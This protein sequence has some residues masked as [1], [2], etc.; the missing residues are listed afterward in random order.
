[1]DVDG[2]IPSLFCGAVWCWAPRRVDAE[3]ADKEL[4]SLGRGLR[5]DALTEGGGIK[6]AVDDG[7]TY[8]EASG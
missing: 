3:D 4:P 2:A 6:D 7:L 8:L 5:A 1:M